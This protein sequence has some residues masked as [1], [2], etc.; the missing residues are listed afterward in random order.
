MDLEKLV[1]RRH[2]PELIRILKEHP[3]WAQGAE[4]GVA[5]GRTLRGILMQTDISMLAVDA[6]EYIPDSEGSGLYEGMD[7]EENEAWVR[8]IADVYPERVHILKGLSHQVARAVPDECLDF[9]FIDASHMEY[10]VKRDI[11]AWSNKVKPTGWIMG[12]DYCRRWDGVRRAVDQTLGKPMT[13]GHTIWAHDKA[14][15]YG[16]AGS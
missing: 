2:A 4:I 9:V 1:M 6:F 15:L 5:M 16:P 14:L 13:F 11:I 7:H 3:E 12:H 10:E 8:A